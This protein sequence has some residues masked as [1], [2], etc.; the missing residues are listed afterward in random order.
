MEARIMD[1][2][3]IAKKLTDHYSHVVEQ[4]QTKHIYPKIVDI[5][6]GHDPASQVYVRQKE[7]KAK[8]LGIQFE[9]VNFDETLTTDDIIQQIQKYNDDP[10][11]TGILV[12]HP[13]PV[14]FDDE[15]IASSIDPMK[16]IDG[17]NAK[18]IGHLVQGSERFMPCTP[19][20]VLKIIEAYKINLSTKRIAMIGKSQIV[21]LPM[22]I[23]LAHT[24]VTV[25]LCHRL[26]QNI[27]EI[28]LAS[29]IIIVAAGDPEF[30]KADMVKPGAVVID[31]G[32]NQLEDGRIVGDC[33]FESVSKVA[34]MITP[35]PGGIGPLT[36]MMLMENTLKA[37]C[38]QHHLIPQK[39][40]GEEPLHAIY[41]I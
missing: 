4:L 41:T 3:E 26:T 2:R 34:S 31:I 21:G 38:F 16:D 36:V 33:E 7:K 9:K 6:V 32:I 40:L 29:D 5:T 24:D 25:T 13:L 11:V 15:L 39:Y 23:I 1:G 28:M 18:N 27:K 22:A 19:R 30:I 12:Q 8:K 17:T 37:A 20:A 35:V 10:Q 14:N